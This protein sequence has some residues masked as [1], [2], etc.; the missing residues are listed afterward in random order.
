MKRSMQVM[1]PIIIIVLVSALCG[2]CYFAFYTGISKNNPNAENQSA[3]I[4]FKNEEYPRV[5]ASF[6]MENLVDKVRERLT[7]NAQDEKCASE[8]EII[9]KLINNEIDIA[10]VPELTNEQREKLVSSGKSFESFTLTKDA[11]V[12]M[13]NSSNS[14]ENLTSSDLV[15]IYSGEIENWSNVGGQDL[16]IKAYQKPA[17]SYVQSLMED[18]VMKN[19]DMK[20]P[21]KENLIGDNIAIGNLTSEYYNEEGRIGY[22]L[23]NYYRIMY[24]NQ[25]EGVYNP[26][27]LLSVDSVSPTT[28]NMLNNSYPYTITYYI[29]INSSNP[30]GNNVRRWIGT[31][32][33]EEG[34]NIIKEAGY[35]AN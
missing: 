4:I 13:T 10:I 5:M 11:L 25:N 27:K 35:I 21:V 26:D 24:N 31:M 1:I 18:K 8:D 15:K 9:D 33:S 3:S 29:I 30:Q 12:F 22:T 23:Y 28:E 17:G 14:I 7:G 32:L 6:A 20:D 34:K 2:G 19:T 16:E